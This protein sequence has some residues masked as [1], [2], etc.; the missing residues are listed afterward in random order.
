MTDNIVP[1]PDREPPRPRPLAQSIESL[2]FS[3]RLQS[4]GVD[5]THFFLPRKSL[6][7][8]V[9][10]FIVMLCAEEDVGMSAARLFD[11]I[12]N[13]DESVCG[14]VGLAIEMYDGSEVIIGTHEMLH[15]PG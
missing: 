15:G 2:K 4:G 11:R 12:V 1:F 10:P 8:E 9:R 5:A 3:F 13:S 6:R 7:S 14:F